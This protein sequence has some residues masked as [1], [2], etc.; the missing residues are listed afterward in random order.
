[1]TI[2]LQLYWE[3][4]KT[5]LFAIG[6]GMATLPFLKD[7]GASTGWYTYSDLM[8]MLAV[9]ESTPGPIGINMATY[10]GYLV[11]GL[12]GAVIATLGEVTPSIIVILLIAV[13]LKNFQDNQ[14]VNW[15]FYGLR[16]A[17]T[18]LIGGACVA[19]MLEVLTFVHI[20]AGGI[21]NTFGLEGGQIFN[22][23]ALALAAVLLVLTNWVKKVKEW[24]PIVFIGLSAVVGVIFHFGGV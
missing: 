23:P 4:F 18:G 24:H 1:M 19:V 16:P 15:A 9:S 5:G 11:G 2:Y 6:G 21:V 8:N 3:F 20:S 22:L 12:P 10:V 13:L 7:I 14:Y 17:S